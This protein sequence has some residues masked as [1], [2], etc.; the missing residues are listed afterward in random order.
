MK[1][2]RP[3]VETIR[4]FESLVPSH[5]EVSV[6][7]VFGHPAAFAAGNMFFG[8]FGTQIYVRLSEV[9]ATQALAMPGAEPFSPMPGRPTRQYV[10]LPPD[11]LSRKAEASRWVERSLS[12]ALA[13]PPKV[14]KLRA[15]ASTRKR[16]G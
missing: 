4:T 10:V 1:M 15:R 12:F 11:V 2:P 8:T 3:S 6:K 14:P 7:K 13:L 9:E 5:P 16:P